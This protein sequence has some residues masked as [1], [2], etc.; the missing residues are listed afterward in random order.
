MH[1]LL[2]LIAICGL[3][4]FGIDVMEKSLDILDDLIRPRHFIVKRVA[5]FNQK[6]KINLWQPRSTFR[7]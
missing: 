7:K 3:W 5:Y 4:L 6:E 2:G 1:L